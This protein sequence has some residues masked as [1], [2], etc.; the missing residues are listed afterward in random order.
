MRIRILPF[1]RVRMLPFSLMRI[2]IRIL[3]FTLSGSGSGSY[4]TV[5][6]GSGF[7]CYHSLFP[8]FGPPMLQNNPLGLPP[9]KF[10]ADPDP[11][12]HFDADP[13]PDRIGLRI[14]N[15]GFWTSNFP[16]VFYLREGGGG[17]RES[18]F[19]LTTF[20][21]SNACQEQ[22]LSPGFYICI[23]TDFSF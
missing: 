14:R 3:P 5:W 13:D 18:S 1:T 10:A 6:C 9:F 2:R 22:G 4:L 7:G 16:F 19:L 8:R 21:G 12:L 15:T 23:S 17:W 11:A 20:C